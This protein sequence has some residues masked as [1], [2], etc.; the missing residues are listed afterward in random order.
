VLGST[1]A[2]IVHESPAPVLIVPGPIE[3][4]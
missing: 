3:P 4:S 1:A 2:A